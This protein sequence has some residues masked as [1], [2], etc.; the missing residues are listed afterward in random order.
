MSRI[1]TSWNSINEIVRDY[2]PLL[3]KKFAVCPLGWSEEAW[4]QYFALAVFLAAI[5]RKPHLIIP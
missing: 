2:V 5:S 3:Q 1:W 4:H